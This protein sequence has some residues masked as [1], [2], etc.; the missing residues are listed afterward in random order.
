MDSIRRS[1]IGFVLCCGCVVVGACTP[2]ELWSHF[3]SAGP[4]GLAAD[5]ALKAQAV[6]R[7][8]GGPSGFGGKMMNGY[9]GHMPLHLG[10][11][12]E[13]NLVEPGGTMMVGMFN[14]SSQNCVF[15]LTY[16]TSPLGTI[17][18]TT[19]V[20]V[21]AGGSVSVQVPCSEIMGMGSLEMPGQPGCHLAN[22]Q[23]VSN[24][25]AVPGFM[26]MD[27]SCG[28]EQMFRLMADADDLDGD[29]D[30]L[31]LIIIS[32]AMQ[33]HMQYGFRMGMDSMM[34]E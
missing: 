9:A 6:A 11:Q 20:T 8:M 24:T 17:E 14:E 7:Q 4:T 2:P 1:V 26:G 23:P 16:V 31:E 34:G 27:Y 29:G 21:P 19:D 12:S 10:F 25:M 5:I 22:G 18:Q 32:E 33:K 15:H 13:T 28:G 3:N 30:R